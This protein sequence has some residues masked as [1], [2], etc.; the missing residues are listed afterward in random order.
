MLKPL[1]WPGFAE[2][3]KF[4]I[5]AAVVPEIMLIASDAFQ[6]ITVDHTACHDVSGCLK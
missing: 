6:Q 1:A 2:K 4:M 3:R 5:D